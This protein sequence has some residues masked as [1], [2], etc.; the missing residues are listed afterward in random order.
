M[1]TKAT[2]GGEKRPAQARL[3]LRLEFPVHV[4][5][6]VDVVTVTVDVDVRTL[7]IVDA[8]HCTCADRAH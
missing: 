4:T 2:F 3:R 1:G 6:E 8:S 5:I 7:W